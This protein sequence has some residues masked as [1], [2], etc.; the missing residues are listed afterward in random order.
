MLERQAKAPGV[1]AKKLK[2]IPQKLKSQRDP[3]TELIRLRNMIKMKVEGGMLDDPAIFYKWEDCTRPW[4]FLKRQ[5][6][7]HGFLEHFVRRPFK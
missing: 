4:C 5:G 2:M 6:T 3:F 1:V 7:A